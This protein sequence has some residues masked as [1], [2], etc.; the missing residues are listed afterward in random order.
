[1]AQIT[2]GIKKNGKKSYY[3]RIRMNGKP[4]VTAV[5]ERLTDA[6]IWISNT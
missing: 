5:F 4:D 2:E 3:V 6:R 1:M